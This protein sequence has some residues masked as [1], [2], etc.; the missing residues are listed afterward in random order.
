[1]LIFLKNLKFW[2]YNIQTSENHPRIFKFLGGF[3]Y[4]E[5][6]MSKEVGFFIISTEILD[7]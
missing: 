6:Y 1:M 5:S 4:F 7:I 2:T 3:P